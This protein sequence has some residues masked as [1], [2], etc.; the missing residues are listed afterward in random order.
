MLSK[1]TSFT[2]GHFKAKLLQRLL[3]DLKV[4]ISETSVINDTLVVKYS[5]P[6]AS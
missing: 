2:V 1:E 5:E 4:E 6:E 3:T